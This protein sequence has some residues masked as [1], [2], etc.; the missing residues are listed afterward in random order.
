MPTP[1]PTTTMVASGATTSLD[2]CDV[3]LGVKPVGKRTISGNSELSI[4]NILNIFHHQWFLSVDHLRANA[5]S[6]QKAESGK[7]FWVKF[8]PQFHSHLV[9][10]TVALVPHPLLKVKKVMFI[11]I[12]ELLNGEGP[13]AFFNL[14]KGTKIATQAQKE[15]KHLIWK[16][17]HTARQES[18]KATKEVA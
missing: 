15:K 18:W 1:T 12:L 11:Y 7:K 3:P 10:C 4:F 16:R 14:M 17:T 5:L 9:K 6:P 8:A 13:Q 2:P